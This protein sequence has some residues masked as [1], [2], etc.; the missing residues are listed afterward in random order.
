LRLARMFGSSASQRL[1]C[2]S[3]TWTQLYPHLHFPASGSGRGVLQNDTQCSGSA[4]GPRKSL[5]HNDLVAA[6]MRLK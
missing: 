3:D 5:L 4:H 2:G 1:A 6:A